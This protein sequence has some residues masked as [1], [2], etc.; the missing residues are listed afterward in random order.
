MS[1]QD[2][3]QLTDNIQQ[4]VH[5]NYRLSHS[6]YNMSE[7][8]PTDVQMLHEALTKSVPQLQTLST[9][10]EPHLANRIDKDWPIWQHAYHIIQE[11]LT[12]RT[13]D[14]ELIEAS[15]RP[16]KEWTRALSLKEQAAVEQVAKLQ[17]LMN[18]LP[19]HPFQ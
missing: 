8:S 19:H 18:K 11:L 13:A 14:L 7:T 3:Q 12:S 15:N 16:F 10:V 17:E 9:L 1:S 5:E 4:A 2:I 6:W